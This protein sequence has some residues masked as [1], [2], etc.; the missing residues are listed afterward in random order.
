MEIS[1]VNTDSKN[2][3]KIDIFTQ[4]N[5][6]VRNGLGGITESDEEL[7]S[8]DEESAGERDWGEGSGSEWR[9][10]YIKKIYS[11]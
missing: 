2:I 7:G 4:K 8:E 3:I 10:R 11:E 1:E 9:E 5:G 6:N